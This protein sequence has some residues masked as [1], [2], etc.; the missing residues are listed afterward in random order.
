MTGHDRPGQARQE[1]IYI[2][3]GRAVQGH[4]GPFRGIQGQGGRGK[5]IL[6]KVA[7]GLA[8][9]VAMPIMV[10]LDQRFKSPPAKGSR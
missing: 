7:K 10:L 4:S 9:V 8:M 3:C 5:L 2:G 6:K 1:P